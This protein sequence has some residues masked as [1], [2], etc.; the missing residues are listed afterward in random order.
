MTW[1]WT[2]DTLG[3]LER[4]LRERGITDGPLTTSRIGDG[5][6]NLT[7]LVSDGVRRVIVRRPPP[8]PVPPGAH[9]M[10]REARLVGALAGSG[11]PVAA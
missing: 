1:E 6:S 2:P 7:Y 11:V 10:L 4:F 5:H 9:D 8:P 3:A